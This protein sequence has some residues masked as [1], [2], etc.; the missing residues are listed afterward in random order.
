MRAPPAGLSRFLNALLLPLR[1][2]TASSPPQCIFTRYPS[3]PT[4]A[5]TS[6]RRLLVRALQ[7]SFPGAFIAEAV[8]GAEAIAYVMRYQPGCAAVPTGETEAS[9]P[10]SCMPGG[11][12]GSATHAD[13]ECIA[14]ATPVS[15]GMVFATAPASAASPQR[16]VDLIVM[17]HEMPVM[18]GSAAT[19]RLRQL[20]VTCA[21]VGATGNAFGRDKD[22]FRASGVDEL[23]AKPINVSELAAWV[24]SRVCAPTTGDATLA[25]VTVN[26]V[27]A[28]QTVTD[29]VSCAESA[30]SARTLFPL[31]AQSAP[32]SQGLV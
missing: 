23:F 32:L 8:D 7:R 16:P 21:I 24:R 2:H 12:G 10:G 5:V 28:T 6:N 25:A 31:P 3:P 27:A 11:D 29:A 22:A 9:L 19:S 13:A 4:F 26:V 14:P 20:G 18:N 17:D 1:D 30:T 15:P